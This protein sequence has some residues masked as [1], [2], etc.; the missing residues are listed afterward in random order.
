MIVVTIEDIVMGV[1]L[2][3]AVVFVVLHRLIERR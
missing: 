1:L 3:V 2:V